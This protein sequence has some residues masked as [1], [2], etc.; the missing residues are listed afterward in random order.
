M[1]ANFEDIG[2]RDRERR[3][4]FREGREIG[5]KREE[6]G[7]GMENKGETDQETM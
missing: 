2:S 7:R 3:L 4:F 5:R 6:V 1:F